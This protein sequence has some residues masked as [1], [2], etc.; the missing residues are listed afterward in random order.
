MKI[1]RLNRLIKEFSKD[2]SGETATQIALIFSAAIVVLVLASVPMLN[3]TSKEYAYNNN[4][5]VDPVVTS[6]IG[7]KKSENKR[8]YTVRKSVFD[9]AEENQPPAGLD[10]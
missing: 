9:V 10:K 2:T 3:E 1:N 8:R 6:S 7:A 4:Y 5:G